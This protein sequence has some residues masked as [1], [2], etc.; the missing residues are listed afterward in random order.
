MFVSLLRDGLILVEAR[1]VIK[2]E[3]LKV[4]EGSKHKESKMMLNNMT[5]SLMDLII[6]LSIFHNKECFC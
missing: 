2:E 5:C 3:M 6:A 1:R 4:I